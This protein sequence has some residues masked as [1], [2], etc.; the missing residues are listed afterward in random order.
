MEN[1]TSTISIA[2]HWRNY[3]DQVIPKWA[4]DAHVDEAKQAFYAGAYVA[5]FTVLNVPDS[6]SEDEK[7]ELIEGMAIEL[8]AFREKAESSQLEQQEDR[9]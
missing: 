4:S 2:N 8:Q 6:L 7:I 3:Q 1:S 9:S 5:L